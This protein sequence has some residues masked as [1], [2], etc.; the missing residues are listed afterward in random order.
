MRDFLTLQEAAE[1]LGVHYMTAYRYVRM[2][3]LT[4]H[5]EAGTWR[6]AVDDLEL[7][8]HQDGSE[9]SE[10]VSRST[11]PWWE[12]LENR[13]L[14][15][16]AGGAWKVVEACLTAG[17]APLDVYS[18]VVAPAL[19]SIGEKWERDELSVADEHMASAVVSRILGRL[20]PRF[21][22]RGRRRGT[23]V[24]AGPPG[25]R[26]FLNLCM[27]A[28]ALRMGGYSAVDLGTDLP[29]EDFESALERHLPVAAV[30]L[31]V[32]NREALEG[33]R[34]MVAAARRILPAAVPVIVGGGAVEGDAHAHRLGA[35]RAADLG[36][37]VEAV[38]HGRELPT[39]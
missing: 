10:R 27:V 4:A 3:Q 9:S 20:G 16:D 6:V 12:R 5:K 23:V 33:C 34:A 2:G 18:T 7:F 36:T 24:V 21:S 19:R 35:D 13:L 29:V 1:R 26:H 17:A 39:V 37:V 31:G 22:R 14:E 15:G 30:C 28:D 8:Q 11:V 38:E 25:E 32:L